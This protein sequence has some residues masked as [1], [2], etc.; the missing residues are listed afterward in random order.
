MWLP[1]RIVG[2]DILWFLMFN[3]CFGLGVKQYTNNQMQ[4]KRY[5]PNPILFLFPKWGKQSFCSWKIVE[6][7]HNVRGYKLHAFSNL[8]TFFKTFPNFHVQLR[9]WF[10]RNTALH[11]T[12]HYVQHCITCNIALRAALQYVQHCITCNIALC[13]THS[14]WNVFDVLNMV[15]NCIE[16]IF[17]EIQKLA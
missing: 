1:C 14:Y 7:S 8:W 5:T 4:N 10:T 11:A 12:L 3:C 17:A 9:R 13:A 6:K 15:C 16:P 2:P